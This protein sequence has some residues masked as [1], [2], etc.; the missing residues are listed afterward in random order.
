MKLDRFHSQRVLVIA[1]AALLPVGAAQATDL[2]DSLKSLLNPASLDTRNQRMQDRTY[3]PQ[4][5]TATTARGAQGPYRSDMAP[6]QPVLEQ[7][8]ATTD[9]YQTA[10][11]PSIPTINE[12][13]P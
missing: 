12:R 13:S 7:P 5:D 4:R 8:P 3:Y 9:Q 11:A 6:D 10:P 1:I 2:Y